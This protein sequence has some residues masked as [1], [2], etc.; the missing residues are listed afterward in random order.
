VRCNAI[1]PGIMLT[2]TARDRLGAEQLVAFSC[3]RIVPRLPEPEDVA[4]LVVFLASDAAW[5]VTGQTF[6]IDGGTLAHR[7]RHGM[8][9]WE[10]AVRAGRIA[11]TSTPGGA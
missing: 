6:V 8:Q 7:P 2:P 5:N 10:A 1:A 11:L 4:P 3:E 9:A